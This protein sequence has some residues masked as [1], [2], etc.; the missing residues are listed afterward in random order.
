MAPLGSHAGPMQMDWLH[1]I[2]RLL[3]LA[4]PNTY[5]WLVMFYVSACYCLAHVLWF[6]NGVRQ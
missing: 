1:V 6:V 3:K 2:E 4:L 5:C